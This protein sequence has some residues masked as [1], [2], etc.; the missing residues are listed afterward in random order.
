MLD[1]IPSL[2]ALGSLLV[3]VYFDTKDKTIPTILAYLFVSFAL[4]Y[5]KFFE[6]DSS[7]IAAVFALLFFSVFYLLERL[8]QLGSADKYIMAMMVLY[9][10]IQAIPIF[11]FS[12]IALGIQGLFALSYYHFSQVTEKPNYLPATPAFL[13]GLGCSLMLAA[14]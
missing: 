2:M 7:G 10:P 5:C 13:V 4:L 6:T 12:S 1:Y 8:D 9:L 14:F 11:A 3:L